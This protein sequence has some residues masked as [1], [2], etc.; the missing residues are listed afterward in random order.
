MVVLNP[1][2]AYKRDTSRLVYWIVKTSNAIITTSPALSDE[3]DAPRGLNTDGRITVAGLVSLSKLIAKHISSVP[4]AILG[5]FKSV[6]R[7][8]TSQFEAYSQL[9]VKQSDPDIERSNASHK[10]F[11]DALSEAFNALGGTEWDEKQRAGPA[12]TDPISDQNDLDQLL[13]ANRFATLSVDDQPDTDDEDPSQTKH[14]AETRPKLPSRKLRQKKA[15]GKG[16][17]AKTK[18][19][20]RRRTISDNSHHCRSWKLCPSR[21]M[22]SSRTSIASRLST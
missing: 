14:N 12:S 1:Y 11:I 15:S 19:R 3:F 17:Q 22:E 18:V 7:A 5:L 20:Q 6:I 8:R 4:H 2:L 16:K 13:F 21:V 9:V 10:H